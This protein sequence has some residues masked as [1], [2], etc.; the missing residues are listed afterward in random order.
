MHS[1]LEK[2]NQHLKEQP[3]D[4]PDFNILQTVLQMRKQRVG[5][6]QTKEQYV[7]CYKALWEE[8]QKLG[9]L[10]NHNNNTNNNSGNGTT[11]EN[12]Q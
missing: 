7:F 9:M 10:D 3:T 8:T 1:T 4:A 2:I 6:V 5:M 11:G 12:S